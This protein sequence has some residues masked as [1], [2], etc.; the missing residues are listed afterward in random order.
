MALPCSQSHLTTPLPG[1]HVHLTM[2][3]PGFSSY[4]TEPYLRFHRHFIVSFLWPSNAW[5]YIASVLVGLGAA[6]IWTGQG[7]YL[8]IMSEPENMSRNS[9]IF[10]AQLQCRWV[11]PPQKSSNCRYFFGNVFL[12]IFFGKLLC[13]ESCIISWTFVHLYI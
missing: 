8:T 1:F 10:W 13:S 2:P 7:N 3:L 12:E 11:F 4:L 6:V 5:L 9:G